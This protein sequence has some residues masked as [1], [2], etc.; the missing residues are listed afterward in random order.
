MTSLKDSFELSSN[1][2]PWK[3]GTSKEHKKENYLLQFAQGSFPGHVLW[4]VHN[5]C[6]QACQHVIHH[7]LPTD[8]IPRLVHQLHTKACPQATFQGFST[9]HLPRLVHRPP[10]KT[11]PQT[12]HQGLSTSH[13]PKL[14][15]RPPAKTSPQ[16]AFQGLS[17]GH[18]QDKTCLWVTEACPCIKAFLQANHQGL[19]TTYLQSLSIYQHFLFSIGWISKKQN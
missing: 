5:P 3:S 14:V 17:T 2:W 16:A 8:H 9:G 6:T 13:L 15:H 11:C 12:T 19:S 1:I 7:N 4:L 10:S 18:L